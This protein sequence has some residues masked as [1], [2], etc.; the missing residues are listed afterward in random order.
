[1]HTNVVPLLALLVACASGATFDLRE[2]V[3]GETCFV[4]PL[5]FSSRAFSYEVRVTNASG[6]AP[7]CD[8]SSI[9]LSPLVMERT[10]LFPG[11]NDRTCS[12]SS[13]AAG[14]TTN[15]AGASFPIT[16]STAQC[17]VAV[18]YQSTKLSTASAAGVTVDRGYVYCAPTNTG[19]L[20]MQN[21]CPASTGA[22]TFMLSVFYTAT[23][24]RCSGSSG[25]YYYS[26]SSGWYSWSTWL[27]IVAIVLFFALFMGLCLRRRRRMQA[28]N[29]VQMQPMAPPPPPPGGP[30]MPPPVYY[31]GGGDGFGGAASP[32]Y[33]APS[34]STPHTT[35]QP[36]SSQPAVW[37]NKPPG[38]TATGYPAV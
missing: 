9:S 6:V 11:N 31:T 18:D 21:A 8:P 28:M 14:G 22:S 38:G 2:S 17:N 33:P 25:S 24:P 36:A 29:A 4:Q 34:V 30:G 19:F 1:M 23:N 32:G 16:D 10:C 7:G 26:S 27:I 12:N 20:Y 35:M 5:T 15:S 13:L 37:Y 3:P